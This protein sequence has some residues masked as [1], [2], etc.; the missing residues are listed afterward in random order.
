MKLSEFVR[1]AV[2]PA[3]LAKQAGV[4]PSGLSNFLRGKRGFRPET[5]AKIVKA[6]GGQVSF[7][8]MVEEM[9]ELRRR[10]AGCQESEP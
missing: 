6:T 5:M 8:D 9:V 4:A 7:E 3:Q 1:T 2:K 10:C